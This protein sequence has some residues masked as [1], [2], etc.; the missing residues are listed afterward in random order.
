MLLIYEGILTVPLDGEVGA[1][2]NGGQ[3]QLGMSKDNDQPVQ[4]LSTLTR[5]SSAKLIEAPYFD[6]EA[7]A[8]LRLGGSL[9][10]DFFALGV[11]IANAAMD[12]VGNINTQLITTS[13][14]SYGTQNLGDPWQWTGS[15]CLNTQIGA[16]A[17]L[18]A[19]IALGYELDAPFWNKPSEGSFTYDGQ[20]PSE[21]EII[22]PGWHGF[23]NKSWYT[24]F[25]KV[26]CFPSSGN[27]SQDTDGD[28]LSDLE[29]YNL[30]ANPNKLDTDGDGFSDKEEADAGTDPLDPAS[31]PV[32]NCTPPQYQLGNS[33]VTPSVTNV[34]PLSGTIGQSAAIT[35]TG[36][37]LPLTLV[38]SID[39][40]TTGCTA[41]GHTPTQADFDCP[42]DAPGA[43]DLAIQSD[44]SA[45]GGVPITSNFTT[46]TVTGGNTSVGTSP[47]NDTGITLC[48]DYAVGGSGIHNND[49]ACGVADAQ[50]DPIPP[51]QD[52]LHG[53][54][55]THNDDSDGHAGFSFTKLDGNGNPLP[56]DAAQWDCVRDNVTGLIWEAKT[57][58][59]GLHD[60][61]WTYTWFEPD[62]SKNGGKAGTQNGGSCAGSACDTYSYVQAVNAQGWCGA[63][64][65]RMP[66]RQELL[67]IADLH[68]V[69]AI[70]VSYF[71]ST[72]DLWSATPSHNGDFAWFVIFS[73]GSAYQ[74]HKSNSVFVRL[75]RVGQ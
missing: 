30:H 8:G 21:E 33:C 54:D 16:G 7:S 60:K 24:A 36:T 71:I 46:F 69:P 59:N 47:L 17:I 55:A 39:G 75:V 56:S 15:A 6:G 20:W 9:D 41:A 5:K 57:D 27:G 22:I 67:S 72:A 37:D 2:L 51:G 35:V 26:T 74:W 43:W 13:P 4:T 42:L 52:A 63:N 29:E 19:R 3:L 53:R 32:I 48:G 14:L 23:Y 61:N 38:L 1:R 31:K 73:D 64:D 25:A 68:R 49:L 45:N 58:D 34:S 65:W 11:Y 62:N 50:G 28:G 44:T 40:Q 18:S 70:D 10:V 12:V 66:R